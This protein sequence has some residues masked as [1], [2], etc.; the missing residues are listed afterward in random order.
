MPDPTRHDSFTL[1][2][3]FE[4]SP[5]AVWQLWADQQL[6]RRWSRMP[7]SSASYEHDF[8]VGGG[9]LSRSVFT[10]PD[11]HTEQLENRAVYFH[12]EPPRR[13][14]FA[15]ESIVAELPRWASLVTVTLAP[16]TVTDADSADTD[17]PDADA[18]PA[19]D[20]TWTEQVAFITPSGDDSHDLPH[21]RGAVQLR[22]TGMG[23][24]L[25]D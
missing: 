9:D 18:A 15:Y 2:R 21:L 17:S 6:W 11:G 25:T 5:D 12:L 13:L 23:L 3:R 22:L 19:T 10:Q 24:A 14:V 7:G 16:A 8:R 20:L 1:T 4:A